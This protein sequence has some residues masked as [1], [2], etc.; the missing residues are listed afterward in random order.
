MALNT[1]LLSVQTSSLHLE[2]ST[3]PG[4]VSWERAL[5]YNA[6]S[7]PEELETPLSVLCRTHLLAPL[8]FLQAP[9]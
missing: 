4:L 2:L 8:F 5:M 6:P 9:S 7:Y 3:I 1:F